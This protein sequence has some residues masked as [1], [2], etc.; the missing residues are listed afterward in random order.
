M[1]LSQG[2][3]WGILVTLY[4]DLSLHVICGKL[5]KLQLF[6]L[7]EKY[8]SK[9]T[10]RRRYP[11]GATIIISRKVLERRRCTVFAYA[12]GKHKEVIEAVCSCVSRKHRFPFSSSLFYLFLGSRQP[13]F[14]PPDFTFFAPFTL[15]TASFKSILFQTCNQAFF[16]NQLFKFRRARWPRVWGPIFPLLNNREAR[17]MVVIVLSHRAGGFIW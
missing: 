14:I 8:E 4:L 2:N 5:F 9:Q 12:R 13:L 3:N 10:W 15:P 11:C 16:F 7:K 1:C 17:G 6:H